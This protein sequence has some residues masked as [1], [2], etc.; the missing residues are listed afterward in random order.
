MQFLVKGSY[1]DDMNAADCFGETP[2]TSAYAGGH[3]NC[4]DWLLAQ[5]ASMNSSTATRRPGI[6]MDAVQ[7]LRFRE[8][9]WLVDRGI[10]VAPYGEKRYAVYS[11]VRRHWSLD[12]CDSTPQTRKDK[13]KEGVK[14]LK[15]LVHNGHV[16]D[17]A[18]RDGPG[19]HSESPLSVAAQHGLTE[20]VRFFLETGV[21]VNDSEATFGALI[22]ACQLCPT[23]F[24]NWLRM[25]YPKIVL[26]LL[27]AGADLGDRGTP[28]RSALDIL[29]SRRVSYPEKHK[30][31]EILLDCGADPYNI[32]SLV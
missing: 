22:R 17:G 3:W 26:L 2:L 6:F 10:N 21:Q 1:Q 13:A 20:A 19:G 29:C 12:E 4:L 23:G 14:L 15:C 11:C 32:A 25:E 18:S 27:E 16:L 30:V 31:I 8:T 24:P 5:G 9:N 28:P 7:R